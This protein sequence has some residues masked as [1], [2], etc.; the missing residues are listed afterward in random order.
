MPT[1]NIN[2]APCIAT[3]RCLRAGRALIGLALLLGSGGLLHAAGQAP[4]LKGMLIA[5][6]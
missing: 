1:A 6:R 5:R 4:A 3:R 2:S